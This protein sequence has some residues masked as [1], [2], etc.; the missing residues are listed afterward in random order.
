MTLNTTGR[1]APK[2][3]D[4]SVNH[5][6][7]N[8]LGA[9]TLLEQLPVGVLIADA[10]GQP[11]YANQ[12]AQRLLGKPAG[13]VAR[14]GSFS[15][16]YEAYRIG[17]DQH[18]PESEL[19]IARALAGE[20]S[21]VDDIEIRRDG[22]DIPIEVYGAPL[23]D[24]SGEIVGAGLVVADVSRSRELQCSLRAE[25]DGLKRQQRELT[26]L[27]DMTEFLQSCQTAEEV[28]AATGSFVSNLF[29]SAAV[30]TIRESRDALV[31]R[32]GWGHC[33]D[34]VEFFS[35]KDCWAM[36]RGQIHETGQGSA[37]PPCPHLPSV[38]G[39]SLCIPMHAHT[40]LVGVLNLQDLPS[41]EALLAQQARLAATV[42]SRLGL[43]LG[44]FALRER[45]RTESIRDPVTLLFNRRYLLEAFE[46][47]LLRARR[48]KGAV[49]VILV[50]LDRFKDYNDR[51]GHDD[52]DQ[53]LLW[54][55]GRLQD[56]AR[57][58]DVVCRYGG[59]EFVILMPTAD[60]EAARARAEQLC[61]QV[62]TLSA[63][64][65]LLRE[66]LTLSIGVAC[67]PTHGDAMDVVL[68][69]AD[70]AMF[71]AKKQGRNQVV[72]ASE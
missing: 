67:F 58:M 23:V 17:T 61:Q 72:V 8:A 56:F 39:R 66:P 44:N 24:A 55:S 15:K 13:V 14:R 59:E 32:Q 35:P 68:R 50:D 46:R 11:R 30:Y 41:N 70:K 38:V 19:P 69:S 26:V 5:P 6:F 33:E 57:D 2:A 29:P 64:E 34:A 21:M 16:A 18:Y 47:D 28:Y 7:L 36:R 65:P 53:A 40:D 43:G 9:S 51:Y 22:A 48:D 60:P 10:S 4:T 31:L 37:S 52:G 25:V 71:E 27:N 62:R 3:A 45:L 63:T 54:L 49:G 20:A 42:A 1:A 12:E